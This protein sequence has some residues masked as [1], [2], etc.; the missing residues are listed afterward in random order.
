MTALLLAPAALSLL[1][2]G[3][4]FLRAGQLPLVVLMM[5]LMGLLLVRRRWAA[6]TVQVALLA[7]AAEWVRA[8]LALMGE[9][10]SLGMPYRRMA[11]ILGA[12]AAVC[13]AS[14]L[15]FR[16]PRVR[17]WFGPEPATGGPAAARDVRPGEP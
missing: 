9:R 6:R 3:A 15:L 17:A 8:T 16:V 10:A 14:T 2:L 13:A 1:V 4:H 7:G 5:A 11:V 12:V